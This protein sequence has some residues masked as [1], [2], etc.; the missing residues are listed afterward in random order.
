[1][2]RQFLL[3]GTV[4]AAVLSAPAWALAA[5]ANSAP[6]A[7]LDEVVVT[8]RKVEE[9]A[10]DV[11]VAMTTLSQ[12]RMKDL[13]I[14]NFSDVARSTPNLFVTRY[15][16]NPAAPLITIRGQA[17]QDVI[18]NI[19]SPVGVYVDGV[20]LPHRSPGLAVRSYRTRFT[21]TAL[22]RRYRFCGTFPTVA[23][24]CR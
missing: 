14:S 24:G 2:K 10:Q 12:V 18:L 22:L 20:Y 19:D 7:Q 8:A 23:R 21:L 1:M 16:S 3:G 6:S 9:R 13:S 15:N 11:P 4:L 17:Q 5:A